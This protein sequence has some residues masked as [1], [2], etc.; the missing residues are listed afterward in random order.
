VPPSDSSWNIR[1]AI[2]VDDG[3]VTL[4]FAGRLGTAGERTCRAALADAASRGR[5]VRLDL[6]E[7]DYLSSAGLAAL[8]DAAAAIHAASGTLTLTRASEPVSAALGLAGGI[9][10]LVELRT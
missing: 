1:T 9:P 8:R 2:E 6:G 7:V 3:I 10:H 4:R 5:V